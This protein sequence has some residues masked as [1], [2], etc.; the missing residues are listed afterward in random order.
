MKSRLLN[1]FVLIVLLTGMVIVQPITKVHAASTYYVTSTADG[2]ANAAN[3]PAG[4]TTQTT[5]RLR[6]AIAAAAS[7]DTI[8]F[9][10]ATYPQ[11]IT[12][13][14]GELYMQTSLT[15]TGAGSGSLIVDGNANGRVFDIASGTTVSIS[16]LAIRN[17]QITDNYGA[18]ILNNG[19]LSL[20]NVVVTNNQSKQ[21]TQLG[22][23]GGI[24]NYGT[25]TIR[26]STLS[27]NTAQFEGGALYNYFGAGLSMTNVVVDH[28]QAST[29]GGGGLAIRG[30]ASGQ[31]VT[32][33][34]VSITNN[35]ASAY[36]GG[37]YSDDSMAITNSLL[38][39][40][41]SAGSNGGLFILDS[42]AGTPAVTITLTNTTV[43]GNSAVSGAGGADFALTQVASSVTLNNTTIADNQISGTSG[44]GGIATSG[45]G[46][47]NVENTIIAGNTSSGIS[48]ANDCSGTI[49]SQD[50]NL[51]QTTSGCTIN[52]T[53][54]NNITGKSAGLS[55]LAQ[56]DGFTETM[57][58]QW[59]SPAVDTGNPA[60][61]GSGGSSCAT[62]DQRGHTRPKDGNG[63]GTAV[64]DIG[65]FELDNDD[66]NTP[67]IVSALPYSDSEDTG[68]FTQAPDDPAMIL[69]P[70][71][72][73][74][75]L[76]SAWY[77]FDPPTT[78]TYTLDTFGSN[79]NTVMTVW[80]GSRGSLSAIACNDNASNAT[81]QSALSVSLSASTTYYIEIIQFRNAAYG[82]TQVGGGTLDFHISDNSA[83]VDVSI[84][85][86]LVGSYALPAGS[87][88][89]QS[90]TNVDNGPVEVNSTNGVPIIASTRINLKTMPTY[91]SYS[92]FMGLPAS[93]LTDTYLFPWYGN[94]NAGGI[95]SQLRFGNVGGASTTVTV[96]IG[97]TVQ[98]TYPLDPNQSTRVSF[99]NLD[100]GP[101]VVQSSGSVPIIAS[102]RINLKTN[103]TYS[104]Y[105]E[106]MG[107]SMGSPLG[108]PSN[109]LSTAYWFPWYGNATVGG[110][111]SQ[112]RFGVP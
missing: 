77:S 8:Q 87:S 49:N 55:A 101:V 35:S 64:C 21:S 18:G 47:V 26:N 110:I 14:S 50:Y 11:T 89:R 90:Y 27:Y 73:D 95:A 24:G 58:L 92:E 108:W 82:P 71:N 30:I 13:T 65:A 56:N 39:D 32:L 40:N 9:I 86:S 3:C 112:L 80:T 20:N 93:Q 70:C 7:G 85:G 51:I 66:F 83:L 74:P 57:A 62:S 96:T 17:G 100:N 61:P 76:A 1:L 102:T 78:Q 16:S 54:T 68:G 75:G 34:N 10:F 45:S 4:N 23:A 19:T 33:D 103:P 69:S 97:G 109:E 106:F 99:T 72:S 36:G 44:S 5:C 81:S 111:A 43:T 60:T 63:D 28:N 67:K 91:S 15:I 42:G 25:L 2:T 12:L 79:Y 88:T 48:T 6:D 94:A 84:G 59:N 53:T 104:S 46:T 105:S 52:G 29:G 37:M 31:S 98:G 22:F 38:A 41:T 107:L